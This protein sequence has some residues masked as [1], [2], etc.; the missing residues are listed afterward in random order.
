[1]YAIVSDFVL[2]FVNR[3]LLQQKMFL[4]KASLA[5]HLR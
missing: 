3:S 5:T 4:A 2:G 1:M